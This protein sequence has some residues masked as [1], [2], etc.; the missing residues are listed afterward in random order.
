M[1]IRFV[2]ELFNILWRLFMKDRESVA[3]LVFSII[4][5]IITTTEG[6]HDTIHGAVV[7]KDGSEQSKRR[8]GMRKDVY[9]TIKSVNSKVE[10]CVLKLLK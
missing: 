1:F 9:D 7:D 3:E 2:K 6:I 10:E 8:M 4:D 5:N